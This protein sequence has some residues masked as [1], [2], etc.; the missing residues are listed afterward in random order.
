MSKLITVNSAGFEYFLYKWSSLSN[1]LLNDSLKLEWHW[2]KKNFVACLQTLQ[3]LQTSLRSRDWGS[4]VSQWAGVLPPL[5]CR[6]EM[7][8]LF[9]A[10][11]SEFARESM[12]KPAVKSQTAVTV[13]FHF[14]QLQ[15][16]RLA[17]ATGYEVV[18]IGQAWVFSLVSLDGALKISNT[19]A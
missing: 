4:G 1:C 19:D 11:H 6:A 3:L 2:G 17:T 9:C 7:R 18:K 10:L 16:S 5:Q 15:G 13:I 8:L 12:K 14:K